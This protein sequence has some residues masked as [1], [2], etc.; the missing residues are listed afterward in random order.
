MVF[1]RVFGAFG[2]GHNNTSANQQPHY[3]PNGDPMADRSGF[4]I[5]PPASMQPQPS[6]MRS[7]HE[8][9]RLQV[10]PHSLVQPVAPQ[11][12]QLHWK[13]TVEQQQHMQQ[14][15]HQPPPQ[16]PVSRMRMMANFFSSEARQQQQLQQQQ[17]QQQHQFAP[18]PPQPSPSHRLPSFHEILARTKHLHIHSSETK[19]DVAMADANAA[20]DPHMLRPHIGMPHHSE[21][22]FLASRYSVT[23]DTSMYSDQ[24]SM[25]DTMTMPSP[26]GSMSPTSQ[27][28]KSSKRRERWTEDEHALFMEGLNRYGRKWK[29]IQAF[30][31]TKTAVQVRTHAYGYFAKL[32]RNMPEDEAAWELAEEMSSLPGPVLKGPSSG[33]RRS[34]PKTDEAGMEVLR[35]FV[36][37]R[38]SD[39]P[40]KDES[41]SG[42]SRHGSIQSILQPSSDD[43]AVE[44][45]ERYSTTVYDM[46]AWGNRDSWDGDMQP[47][48]SPVEMELKRQRIN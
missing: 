47:A 33:K 11:Q 6:H 4:A 24:A 1:Q 40:K 13:A 31:K 30:V 45:E 15:Q 25:D 48:G 35:R 19:A 22:D 32:L 5:M 42:R 3:P 36:F 8:L 46:N 38:R 7:H 21:Q 12:P 27:S 28:G 2:G 9:P 18:V 44:I 39:A 17:L 34:E 43:D 29:K 20:S 41:M 14:Q 23:S 26:G 37:R 10:P 16:P